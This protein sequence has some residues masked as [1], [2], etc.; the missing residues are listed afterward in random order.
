M[1]WMK[2]I[3]GVLDRYAEGGAARPPDAAVH[4][5]FDRFAQAAPP[6]AVADG[7]SAAFRSDQTPPFP[8]MASQLF[9]R[10]SATQ[11]ANI[12]NMLL[13]TVGPLV[14][15]QILA[16]RQRG[17]AASG[18]GGVLGQILR[19]G[20]SAP[21]VTPEAADQLDPQDIED[22]AKEAEKKDPSVIDKISQVYAQQPQLVKMLGGAALAIVLARMAQKR[23]AI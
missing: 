4:E 12:L 8:Q 2:E 19:G 7:L 9:G 11:R 13:T 23:G 16:R 15:Q 1:D 21:Q 20:S 17:T 5:D 6:D 3:G 10:A 14:V 22:I 18:Q